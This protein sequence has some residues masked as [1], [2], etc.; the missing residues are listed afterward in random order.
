MKS[1]LRYTLFILFIL[2]LSS[3]LSA[4]GGSTVSTGWPG[5]LVDKDTAYLAMNQHVYAINL[6]DGKEKWRFPE[7]GNNNV[8][9]YARPTLTEDGQLLVGGYDRIL[10]SLNPANG[11]ENQG[12]WPYKGAKDRY[13]AGPLVTEKTIY[14]PSAD[15]LLTALNLDGSQRWSF[16]ANSA[17]WAT[18]ATNGELIFV[19]SYDHVLYALNAETGAQ[20]WATQRLGGGLVGSPVVGTDNV[21]FLGSL[22]SQM[23]A[24][25]A[26]NGK[27]LWTYET[28]GWV[29]ASPVL[30]EDKLYFGD[31][32]GTFYCLGTDGKEIWKIQPDLA[33]RRS[34][35]DG[36]LVKD[37]TAY[38]SSE[39][40]TLFAID[41]AT[42]NPRWNK[43][44]GGKLY[45]APATAGDLILVAPEGIDALLVAVDR[46]GNQK[47]TF[48]PEKK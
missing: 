6:A 45:T 12:N 48:V 33:A 30:E 31:L 1:S 41:I 23:L 18:P 17:L 28:S 14:A 35:A 21:L 32:K 40:G 11:Q 34:I 26:E 5:L 44:I 8:T 15:G 46:N 20:A 24:L 4:C 42:G 19:P 27:T 13:L 38:F 47:W 7:K 9:F 2:L 22:G 10:Y 3:L 39:S 36:A 25:D 43:P 29:W 16:K 37:D